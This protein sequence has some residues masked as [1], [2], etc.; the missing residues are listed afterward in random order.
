MLSLEKEKNEIDMTNERPFEEDVLELGDL[1]LSN[2]PPP[3]LKK[4]TCMKYPS[5]DVFL[6]KTSGLFWLNIS[7]LHL[8]LQKLNLRLFLSLHGSA[9][10]QF[11]K[12]KIIFC[13]ENETCALIIQLKFQQRHI[14]Q[15]L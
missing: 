12:N 10:N 5:K 1:S 14:N 13:Q 9:E 15:K 3:P 11:H 2:S 8:L 4:G 7:L 6:L